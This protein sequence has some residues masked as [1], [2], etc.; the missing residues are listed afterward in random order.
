MTNHYHKNQFKSYKSVIKILFIIVICIGF[1]SC[2]KSNKKKLV[3]YSPHGKEMLS[4]FEKQFEAKNPEI[5]V[6]WLD[7]GSQEIIDRVKTE[8]D[9]PQ[10]DIWW[11]AP[12][13]LFMR[14]DKLGL[15]EKYTPTWS[16]NI[17]AN[18]KGKNDT[19]YGTFLTP[20]VISFNNKVLSNATAPQDWADL[21]QPEWKDKIVLRAPMA[22]GTLRVI[23]AAMISMSVKANGSEEKGWEWLRG[24]D[25]NTKDY[26]SDP[27][28]MYL[29]LAGN[30]EPV[31]LWNMPDIILQANSYQ[32]PFG[33]LFPKS[34]TVVLTDGIALVKGSKNSEEAK[35]FY[36]FVTSPEAMKLQAEKFYRIPARTD[37][38]KETLPEWIKKAEYKE[39]ELDWEMIS[40]KEA[41]WMKKWDAE[42]KGKK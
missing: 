31:T 30:D 20:E 26:S 11:G 21:V 9:N 29:K 5:D 18:H 4:E 1:S 34:G 33:Y 24:L 23:F 14:A 40:E 8:K 3:V 39:L 22:S 19:W 6:Q 2:S 16:A 36:E 7:M 15:L 25:R 41:D 35:K 10:A 17:S 27:T 13:T 42:I 28:Q 12:A 38:P 32:Y 37:I